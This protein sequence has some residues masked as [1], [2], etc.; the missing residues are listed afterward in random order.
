MEAALE[1][2][3]RGMCRNNNL[4]GAVR[5]IFIGNIEN[6]QNLPNEYLLQLS[7]QMCFGFFDE[8]QMQRRTVLFYI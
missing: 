5:C 3:V 1:E 8:D 2:H 7:V 4:S 6:V